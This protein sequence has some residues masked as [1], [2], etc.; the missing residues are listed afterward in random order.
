MKSTNKAVA[1][2]RVSTLEQ[3]RHGHGIDI[4]M[5]DV[6]LFAER[7]GLLID[8]FY[9]DEG[10]SGINEH[11]RQLRL[12][13]RDCRARRVHA[14]ILPSLDRLSRDVRI[15]ENVFYEFRQLGIRVLIADMPT[16]DAADRKDV[17]IRQIREAIAEE[18]RKEIVERLWKGRQERVRR[19]LSA[20][21]NLPYGFSRDGRQ[22]VVNAQ[23]AAV[24]REIFHRRE[25]GETPTM[26]ASA[27]D[28]PGLMRRNGKRW[29]RRQV[30]GVLQRERFY[31][32]GVIQYGAVTGQNLTYAL[33]GRAPEEDGLAK[34]A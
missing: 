7:Q 27:L 29:T 2:C 20:G 23:E 17:M 10:E 31:R 30:A 19:G 8:R 18:N 13:L 9:K 6:S 24:I 14:V 25:C 22:C 33:I 1:Y 11:R 5:R 34:T 12:L 28:R 26:I 21:G 4:Q 15:A 16:Y 32:E 3:K